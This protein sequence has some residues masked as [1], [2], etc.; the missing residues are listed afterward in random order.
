VF[1]LLTYLVIYVQNV[2]GYSAIESGVRFLCLS[3]TS[4]FAAA[5]AGRL[6]NR[7][8]TKWLIAPGFFV[9]TLGLYLL[10]GITVH[11]AWTGLIPGLLICGVGIG[12]INVP[13]ASTA[14]GVV[15]PE[16]AGMAS[17]V[18]ST[19]RQVGIAC[20]IAALG[21]IFATQI[22]NG[23]RSA[24]AGTPVAAQSG[25]IGDAIT[26]GQINAVLAQAPAS[27]R[28]VIA[29]AATSSFVDA[30]NHIT[31]LATIVAG[32]AGVLCLVLIRAKDFVQQ[33]PPPAASDD[34]GPEG[35]HVSPAHV[36]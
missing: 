26:G 13:L 33:G 10:G 19:F 7:V 23:V 4:F 8:P 14:V 34:E 2:L 11:S 29:N 12:L 22:D 31:L 1:S 3:G 24:L 21:S 17:G 25:R 35:R 16:R 28:G 32:V 36:A 15:R 9:L 30:L 5:A 27:A 6:T 20:G 18:N